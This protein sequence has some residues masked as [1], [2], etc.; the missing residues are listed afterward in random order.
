MKHFLQSGGGSYPFD[1]NWGHLDGQDSD[2][3]PP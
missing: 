1:R 3:G 2:L